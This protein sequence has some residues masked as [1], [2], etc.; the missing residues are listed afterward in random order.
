MFSGCSDEPVPFTPEPTDAAATVDAGADTDAEALEDAGGLTDRGVIPIRDTGSNPNIDNTVV[1]AHDDNELYAVDPRTNRLRRIAAF[2]WP[3][4]PHTSMTDLAVDAMGEVVACSRDALYR[5]DVTNARLTK[6]TNFA[7]SQVF[8]GLT[9]LPAGVLDADREVLVGATSNGTYYRIDPSNGRL[10]RLGQFQNSWTLS[11]DIVSIAGERTYATV[12]R[13]GSTNDSLAELNT[14][15]G[16]LRIIGDTGFA[17]IYG[18]GYWRQTLY[19]FTRA[20][21]FI[22]INSSTGRGT[23][24]SMP[25]MEF[26]GAGVTTTAPIAPP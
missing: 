25:T 23:R 9:Y 10:T 1:Y 15:T 2:V 17:S 5:V 6:I 3:S 11:G 4:G 16:S 26:S 21:E 7:E 24:Q 22:T 19:G 13:S 14:R 18:L 12:R 20:G 8:Y